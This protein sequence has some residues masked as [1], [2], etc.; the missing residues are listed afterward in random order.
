MLRSVDFPADWSDCSGGFAAALGEASGMLYA[1]LT[2]PI[3]AFS[4]PALVT[5]AAA[6]GAGLENERAIHTP[7]WNTFRGGCADLHGEVVS[8]SL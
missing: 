2:S 7:T 4:Y 1:F 3:G 6:A 8:A 5:A